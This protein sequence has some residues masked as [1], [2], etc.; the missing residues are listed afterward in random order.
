M[1]L[2]KKES[3]PSNESQFSILSNSDQSQQ[4]NLIFTP[5]KQIQNQKQQTIKRTA[6]NW[7]KLDEDI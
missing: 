3:N 4:E 6:T 7:Y 5:L 2:T 1:K